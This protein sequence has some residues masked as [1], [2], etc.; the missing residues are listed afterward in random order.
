[1]TT[2]GQLHN[3]GGTLGLAMPFAALIISLSLARNPAWSP[4]RHSLLWAAGLAVVGFL[5]S[6]LSLGFMLSQ[7]GG[8]FGPGVLV[9]WPNR[10]EILTY[11]VWLMV[12]AGHAARLA[13]SEVA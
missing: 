12:V 5:V 9:G 11:S 13:R 1:M 6:F 8:Q 2:E 3:L 4:V 7:S 10:F